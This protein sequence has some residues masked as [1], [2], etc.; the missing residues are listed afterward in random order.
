MNNDIENQITNNEI[1]K[2]CCLSCMVYISTTVLCVIAIH[3]FY[4]SFK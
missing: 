2:I 4:N 1:E 3:A